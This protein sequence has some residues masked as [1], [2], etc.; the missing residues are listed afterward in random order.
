MIP[1]VPSGVREEGVEGEERLEYK[2]LTNPRPL[3]ITDLSRSLT[4]EIPPSYQSPSG[5]EVTLHV[6]YKILSGP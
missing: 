5:T 1:P 6:R 3:L 2:H 4:T